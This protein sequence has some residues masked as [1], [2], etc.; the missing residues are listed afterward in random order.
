MDAGR[1][2]V[3]APPIWRLIMALIRALP[4]PVMRRMKS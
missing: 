2:V 1:P 3:Y 4:R